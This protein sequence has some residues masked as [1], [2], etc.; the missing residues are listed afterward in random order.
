MK[1][2]LVFDEWQGKGL[3]PL[4][5]KEYQEVVNS[6][7]DMSFHAA[8]ARASH[9]T[10]LFSFFLQIRNLMRSVGEQVLSVPSVCDSIVDGHVKILNAI[11]ARDVNTALKALSKQF[12][13]VERTLASTVLERKHPDT[14]L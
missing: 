8:L 7:A 13:L 5:T 12:N 3:T 4:T 9:N 6:E 10:L 11:K 1:L 2:I 14:N